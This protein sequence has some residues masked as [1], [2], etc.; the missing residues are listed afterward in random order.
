LDTTRLKFPPPL[1]VAWAVM[2]VMLLPC[3][4]RAVG[5]GDVVLQSGLGDP[6]RARVSLLLAKGEHV[7]DACF[8]LTSPDPSA[9][10]ASG[11]LT[12]AS[13]TLKSEGANSYIAI[14]SRQPLNEAYVKLRLQVKCPGVGTDIRT[15]TLLPDL[16]IL[17][18]KTEAAAA[19]PVAAA[20]APAAS[21]QENVPAPIETRELAPERMAQPK[22]RRAR[23]PS[24]RA[25]HVAQGRRSGATS[26]FKLKL[27]GNP[28][29]ESRI[30]KISPE[31]RNQLLARQ[32]FLDTDDQM[33]SFL[34]LQQQVRDL[35][36]ALAEI[37]LKLAPLNAASPS[38]QTIPAPAPAP[39]PAA[40]S[41][42]V[43]QENMPKKP[44][45]KPPV[46]AKPTAAAQDELP[47]ELL[48]AIG[49]V[50]I[51]LALWLGWRYYTRSKL[52]APSIA[53]QPVE[54]LLNFADKITPA[55]RP[56][57]IAPPSASGQQPAPA[58][59]APA[60]PQQPQTIFEPPRM[61][62]PAALPA[63][64]AQEEPEISEEDLLLEEAGLYATHGRPA[65]AV[66][67]LQ[68]LVKICPTKIEAWSLLLSIYSS[69]A[70]TAEFEETARAFREH[71]KDSPA[72]GGIQALGRTL[73]S[74][75][76][77]YASDGSSP[78]AKPVTEMRRPVGDI[79]MEM[80]ALSKQDLQR[81]LDD[82]DPKTHGRFGGYLVTRKVITL[83]QLDQALL[84]QQ[85]VGAEQKPE[86][87]KPGPPP[88]KDME[89]FLADFDLQQ[90]ESVAEPALT[91]VAAEPAEAP[92]AEQPAAKS[93]KDTPPV[94]LD[95]EFPLFTLPEAGPATGEP[96]A[97][98]K[99]D[100][101]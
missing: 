84:L 52:H 27:S 45:V 93:R 74:H 73:D 44:A 56:P 98:K 83:A 61:S 46:A 26:S 59:P 11:Y 33:A 47:D 30:G 54:P 99:P 32:K 48:G 41:A 68:H 88:I 8:S 94:T 19:P 20:A 2:L 43:T 64:A 51:I 14:E 79:L 1:S 39:V 50:A 18:P 69:L 25:A 62:A 96:P 86:E 87:E 58:Q 85:G 97:D 4:A 37:K 60:N 15:L 40:A 3:L 67:V 82:F 70:K 101:K 24:H 72:W 29:D 80:G 21:P 76:P 81:C 65:K 6:L 31:E 77:L 36:A 5:I 16:D 57:A 55:P 10:D 90:H 89:D 13:L 95:F 53:P 92:V 66:E 75:N 49:L 22:A 17:T 9:E 100:T 12:Q 28:M 34:A 63:V 35:Q 78:A 7:D 23:A 42:A 91:P 71:F 38:P